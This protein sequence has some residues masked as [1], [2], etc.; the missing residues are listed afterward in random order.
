MKLQTGQLNDSSL[1]EL[2]VY[3]LNG[4]NYHHIALTLQIITTCIYTASFTPND[5]KALDK[6]SAVT[7]EDCY[8]AA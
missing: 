4:Q 6:L 3:S 2:T 8:M 1:S 7:T 5:P